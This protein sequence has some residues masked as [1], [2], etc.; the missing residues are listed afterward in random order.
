MEI[1]NKVWLELNGARLQ[2]EEMTVGASRG[3]EGKFDTN[4]EPIGVAISS[5]MGE[6][7]FKFPTPKGRPEIDFWSLFKSKVPFDLVRVQ[8]GGQRHELSRSYVTKVDESATNGE[9]SISVTITY[10]DIKEQ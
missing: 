4:G 6:V 5:E 10:A 3:V 9:K 2:V 1:V 8:E 7:T